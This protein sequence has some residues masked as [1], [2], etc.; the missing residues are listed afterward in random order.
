MRDLVYELKEVIADITSGRDPIQ[1][2]EL[3]LSIKDM[4]M[5]W[6]D[7]LESNLDRAEQMQSLFF[8]TQSTNGLKE[9]L[10]RYK[11]IDLQSLTQAVQNHL[12]PDQAS[13]LYVQP[14]EE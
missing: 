9:T 3:I 14:K 13:V 11:N 4:E 7:G 2:K 5:R 8:H 10:Q 12:K 1:E 6:Y